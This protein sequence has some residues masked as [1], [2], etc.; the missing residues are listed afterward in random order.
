MILIHMKLASKLFRNH[1]VIRLQ[2]YILKYLTSMETLYGKELG[3][4]LS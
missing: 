2:K 3:M 4:K 1:D